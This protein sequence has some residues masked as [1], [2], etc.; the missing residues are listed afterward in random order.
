MLKFKKAQI[1]NIKMKPLINAQKN[2]PHPS[3]SKQSIR[4]EYM[5]SVIK[6]NAIF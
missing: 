5:K 4:N 6:Q 1:S 2:K 3:P